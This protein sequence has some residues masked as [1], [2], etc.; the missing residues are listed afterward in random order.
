MDGAT[1]LTG[2]GSQDNMG[3]VEVCYYQLWGMVSDQNWGDND[4]QV[5]C[6]ELGYKSSGGSQLYT[7]V[8][9]L[10]ITVGSKSVSDSY[11]GKPNRTVHISRVSCGGSE[12]ALRDCDA[13]YLTL[14]DGKIV[15]DHI[16]AAGVQCVRNDVSRETVLVNNTIFQ[17]SSSST[18]TSIGL[19]I[20]V[21]ILIVGLV[22]SVMY[23]C[24]SSNNYNVGF[25]I[26]F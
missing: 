3:T 12:A 13:I 15:A 18:G 7:C 4:A 26:F 1:R 2:G 25:F 22:L 11:Y 17:N 23:V 24:D 20:L 21:A 10:L 5:V 16:S 8:L 14:E 6:R 19:G 9:P